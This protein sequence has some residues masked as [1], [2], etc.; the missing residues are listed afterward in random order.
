MKGVVDIA[1]QP[2]CNIFVF[3]GVCFSHI[4]ISSTNNAVWIYETV[5]NTKQHA[6]QVGGHCM[7]ESPTS[8][9]ALGSYI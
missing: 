2:I 8:L 6:Y 4:H 1:K 3:C 5:W 7:Y 9:H